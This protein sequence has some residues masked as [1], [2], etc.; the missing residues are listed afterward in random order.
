MQ[1]YNLTLQRATSITHAVHGN[2]SGQ[3]Q[4]EI[5]VARGT[6]I[7]ILKEFCLHIINWVKKV[8]PKI[9]CEGKIFIK[10]SNKNII[11]LAKS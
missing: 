5:A 10:E 4:Q 9:W 2:Y 7:E 6:M 3:K 1:L 8:F 11:M